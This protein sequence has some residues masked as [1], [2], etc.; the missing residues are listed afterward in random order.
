MIKKMALILVTV[1]CLLV[2]IV[3]AQNPT[4]GMLTPQDHIGGA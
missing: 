3:P 2:L 1:S 4:S